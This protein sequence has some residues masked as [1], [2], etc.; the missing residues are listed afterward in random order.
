M[1]A[2]A[3]RSDSKR[4]RRTSS[5]TP[6]RI[7]LMATS[8]WKGA[9]C[10]ASQTWPMPTSP[11]FRTKRYGPIKPGEAK[12]ASV[13]GV[14]PVDVDNVSPDSGDEGF[15][16]LTSP[17]GSSDR[18]R[19]PSSGSPEIAISTLELSGGNWRKAYHENRGSL[20]GSSYPLFFSYPTS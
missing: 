13:G 3:W 19:V 11:S 8:R 6:A 15:V 9:V 4:L 7:S 1:R 5:D 14:Y 17:C 16:F 20:D 18:L 10:S 12:L 2:R